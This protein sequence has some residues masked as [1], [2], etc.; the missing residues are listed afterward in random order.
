ERHPAALPREHVHRLEIRDVWVRRRSGR[1]AVPGQRCRRGGAGARGA[2]RQL[3]GGAEEVKTI[4]AERF[5]A[6]CL[7]ILD[8]VKRRREPVF[9]LS[10]LSLQTSGSVQGVRTAW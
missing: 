9:P 6:R 2:R 5:E 4:S 7:S 8:E 3:D 1:E 10:P